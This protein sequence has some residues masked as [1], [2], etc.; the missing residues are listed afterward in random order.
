MTYFLFWMLAVTISGAHFNPATS[1]AVYLA[2]GKYLR[3]VGRLILYWLFQLMGAFAGILMTW[4]IFNEPLQGYLLW[5]NEGIPGVGATRFFS[6]LGNIYYVKII[7]LEFWNA[8]IFTYVYLLVIYKPSIRTVDEIVKGL[9]VSIALYACWVN[10]AESGGSLN[11]A[12]G[13]AQSAYQVGF[14]N[15]YDMNGNRYASAIW[16][17]AVFPLVG[18]MF[19]A[20]LFRL[21]IY[22]DN[23]ALRQNVIGGGAE[24]AA[25]VAVAQ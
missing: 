2:E 1:L 6:H 16:V 20:L 14:L 15:G 11:P 3:Q 9:A 25:G 4:L 13:I 18:A 22:F 17:Y 5:P 12:L 7:W 23:K 19:A 21:H 24:R 10:T 8:M